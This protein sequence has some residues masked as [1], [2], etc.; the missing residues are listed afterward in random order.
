MITNKVRGACK[1]RTVCAAVITAY[2][3]FAPAA[4]SAQADQKLVM[5]CTYPN[6]DN[7]MTIT[8][9]LA[10]QKVSAEYSTPNPGGIPDP[11]L[12][13]DAGDVTGI[14]DDKIT[15]V[16]GLGTINQL[17]HTLNRYTGADTVQQTAGISV[18]TCHKQQKQ[19]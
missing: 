10:T 19:F 15:F 7:R 5:D 6:R 17:V 12:R 8:L 14:A 16:T 4:S 11:I 3:L 9:D 1:P 18:W 13:S 2:A